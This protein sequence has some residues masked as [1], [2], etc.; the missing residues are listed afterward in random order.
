MVAVACFPPSLAKDLSAPRY[1][2]WQPS[3]YGSWVF[4]YGSVFG[5]S[6][7]VAC[8]AAPLDSRIRSSHFAE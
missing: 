2:V 5:D 1:I 4:F 7:A 8:D 6:I 3:L